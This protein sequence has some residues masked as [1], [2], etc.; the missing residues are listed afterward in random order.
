MSANPH[1]F[2][3]PRLTFTG[4]S[5]SYHPH[6]YDELAFRIPFAAL[7]SR[8]VKIAP[9]PDGGESHASGNRTGIYELWS[10]NCTTH[11]FYPGYAPRPLPANHRDDVVSFYDGHMGPGD[12]TLYPQHYYEEKPWLGFVRLPPAADMEPYRYRWRTLDAEFVP[13]DFVWTPIP[14]ERT[15]AGRLNQQFVEAMRARVE[16]LQATMKE[17]SPP[18]FTCTMD[19]DI[20]RNRPTYPSSSDISVL[21]SRE[22]WL[23]A[24]LVDTLTPLQRGMKELEAWILMM[25]Y[26]GRRPNDDIP[27]S[28]ATM[29]HFNGHSGV[30]C[31]SR[32]CVGVW[33][34]GAKEVDAV[35]LLAIGVIPVYIIHRLLKG[36]DYPDSRHPNIPDRRPQDCTPSEDAEDDADEATLTFSNFW[37]STPVEIH[38][39]A[40]YSTYLRLL[41]APLSRLCVPEGK[42]VLLCGVERK[43]DPRASAR[44]SSWAYRVHQRWMSHQAKANRADRANESVNASARPPPSLERERERGAP[45]LTSAD[46][47]KT[48][49]KPLELSPPSLSPLSYGREATSSLPFSSSSRTQSGLYLSEGPD[50]ALGLGFGQG[51]HRDHDRDPTSLNQLRPSRIGCEPPK[52]PNLRRPGRSI[53]SA[54]A[55]AST[56][57]SGRDEDMTSNKDAIQIRIPGPPL[58]P[59]A[60][61]HH[62]HHRHGDL[63]SQSQP[64]LKPTPN[65]GVPFNRNGREREREREREIEREL[66]RKRE[67]EQQEEQ[68][69][70]WSRPHENTHQLPER[71]M[72][73]RRDSAGANASASASGRDGPKKETNP[74]R[75]SAPT[76]SGG[77]SRATA[78][79]CIFEFELH[80]PRLSFSGSGP[81]QQF[82]TTASPAPEDVWTRARSPLP[83]MARQTSLGKRLRSPS[84]ESRNQLSRLHHKDQDERREADFGGPL[85]PTY[86]HT[87]A[88]ND[89]AFVFDGIT[90]WR[91][92]EE[93]AASVSH[94]EGASTQRPLEPVAGPSTVT[95]G[96]LLKMCKSAVP[97]RSHSEN[98]K[99]NSSDSER[100]REPEPDLDSIQPVKKKRRRN[101]RKKRAG[102]RSGIEERF[103]MRFWE[104]IESATPAVLGTLGPVELEYVTRKTEEYEA[105]ISAGQVELSGAGVGI[106]GSLAARIAEA[107]ELARE[108]EQEQEP[109]GSGGS[110]GE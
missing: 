103:G 20:W 65:S 99:D 61:H 69:W 108:Q 31:A 56:S 97:S 90:G 106:S 17:R 45:P 73:K 57:A 76:S 53:F 18:M 23:W 75:S 93:K 95:L 74:I 50:P 9:P 54:N 70:T 80:S 78:G 84:P 110:G 37:E 11:Q 35:W 100:E 29:A 92:E 7:S 38:Q 51:P 91:W 101:R 34:N 62:H 25:R 24:D 8:F 64:H 89:R 27:T 79:S 22:D 44:S 71:S 30:S 10:P 59:P 16:V 21:E 19:Y 15:G 104:F 1:S 39:S 60:Q 82:R 66:Q 72:S 86:G 33:L 58:L 32:G 13:A 4:G 96:Y 6:I 40:E 85:S 67:R 68:R 28:S 63:Q 26:W 94:S 5:Y 41:V 77:S 43:C 88:T 52:G 42:M 36:L 14:G 3:K 12:W 81:A 98:D 109:S 47:A 2:P 49:I 46:K 105:R 87:R 83:L 107:R 102:I 48:T 55:N